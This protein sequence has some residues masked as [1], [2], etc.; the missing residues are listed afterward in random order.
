VGKNESGKTAILKALHKL[1]P[2]VDAAEK[3]E[4]D[5]DYPKRK[6]RPDIP[7]PDD[8]SAIETQWILDDKDLAQ[9]EKK[10]GKGVITNKIF[11]LSNGYENIRSY[12]ISFDEHKLVKNLVD[13]TK[14]DAEEKKAL[15]EAKTIPDI[16][17]SLESLAKR[18]EKQENLFQ[19]INKEY[20]D[21]AEGAIINMIDKMVPTFLY[22]DQYLRLPG[23]VS[24]EALLRKKNEN[25]LDDQDRIFIALLGLAGTTIETV[26]GAKTFEEFNSALRAVSN[27]ISDQIFKYWTQNRHLDVQMRLDNARPEDPAPF[28]SGYVFRTR[29]DN[30]RHRADTG[31]DERSS[32]FV[33]FFSFLVWFYRLRES[34]KGNLIILLDE[35]GLTLHARAQ[36][37]LLRYINEQLKPDYQVI[38]TTHS[39]F[40]I[41]PDNLL[42][43][44]T[45]EDVVQKDKVTGEEKLL[46]TKISEEVLSTDPDTISPL[47]RALDYE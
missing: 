2:A 39:P 3:F 18:T 36:A 40:M 14:P 33:W 24:V 25:K 7:V 16:R 44:R 17:K 42:S 20:K 30:K 10:F 15:S 8:P 23:T 11:K 27:Q 1:K 45:V 37:D 22:F 28:N 9:L 4:P 19:I 29:I 31:F 32:G 12:D 13:S 6:W 38:Y 34:Y 46:G 47:Q 35:P 21:G 43:A 5:K 41:D 26:H